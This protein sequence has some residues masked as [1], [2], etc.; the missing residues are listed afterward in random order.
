M[1]KATGSVSFEDLQ[2]HIEAETIARLIGSPELVDALGATTTLTSSEVK[3]LVHQMKVVAAKTAFG[4][5]A[6]V[7]DNRMVFGM[8]RMLAIISELED[9]PLVAVFA[10]VAEGLDWLSSALPSSQISH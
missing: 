6:V 9:G 1:T 8:A 3:H 5:T 4:P 7:T 10:T 2:R